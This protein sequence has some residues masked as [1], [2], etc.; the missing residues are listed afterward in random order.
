MNPKTRDSTFTVNWDVGCDR[1]MERDTTETCLESF[2]IHFYCGT[3]IFVFL[4]LSKDDLR[5]IFSVKTSSAPHHPRVFL[6][7]NGLP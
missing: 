3:L 4:D 5:I 2:E 1:E 6:L 7:A